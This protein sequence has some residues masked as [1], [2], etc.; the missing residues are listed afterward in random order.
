MYRSCSGEKSQ[1][2]KGGSVLDV[3]DTAPA[4]AAAAAAAAAWDD[5]EADRAAAAVAVLF[6]IASPPPPRALPVLVRVRV[7]L[8]PA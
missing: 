3:A 4:T 6:W 1:I 5:G 8:L 2:R 7:L